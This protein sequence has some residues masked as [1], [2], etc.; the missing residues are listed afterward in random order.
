MR[1]RPVHIWLLAIL[2]LWFAHAIG[3]MIHEYAHSFTAWLLHTKANPWL[4][5][6]EVGL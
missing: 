2:Q 1:P 6:M 5:T 4:S 3:F